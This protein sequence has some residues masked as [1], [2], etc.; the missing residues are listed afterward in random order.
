[1]PIK[2]FIYVTGSKSFSYFKPRD[3]TQNNPFHGD[4]TWCSFPYE[5][6]ILHV[7]LLEK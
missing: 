5:N 4:Y 3:S 7:N 6:L 2:C 1:M